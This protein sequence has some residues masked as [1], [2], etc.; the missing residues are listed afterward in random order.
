MYTL[1]KKSANLLIDSILIAIK[2]I[3]ILNNYKIIKILIITFYD[4]IINF[5][6]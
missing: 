2:L 5:N 3:N 6:C 4:L 1:L